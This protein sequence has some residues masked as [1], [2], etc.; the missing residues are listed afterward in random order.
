MRSDAAAFETLSVD[1]ADALFRI[2]QEALHN[3]DR[4]SNANVIHAMLEHRNGRI[5]L[6]IEDDGAGF[7]MNEVRTDRFGMR[8]MRERAEMI[9]ARL[10]IDSMLGHG[11]RVTVEFVEG[12]RALDRVT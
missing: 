2:A 11:T 10:R 9:G 1:V 6:Q 5:L 7:D 12:S 3:A 8:G 4:H